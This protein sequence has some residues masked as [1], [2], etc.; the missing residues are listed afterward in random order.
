MVSPNFE[1]EIAHPFIIHSHQCL[2]FHNYQVVLVLRHKISSYIPILLIGWVAQYLIL[3]VTSWVTETLNEQRRHHQLILLPMGN[4]YSSVPLKK[5]RS[6]KKMWMTE[7]K[8]IILV[9]NIKENK[10]MKETIQS[11]LPR[12]WDVSRDSDTSRTTRIIRQHPKEIKK[13]YTLSLKT[14]PLRQK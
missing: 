11:F 12:T 10:N 6:P 8:K 1:T 4:F 2:I 5:Q 13:I 3:L 14:S 7:H 9:L